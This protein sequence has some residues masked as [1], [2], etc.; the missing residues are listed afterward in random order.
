MYGRVKVSAGGTDGTGVQGVHCTVYSVKRVQGVH[1]TGGTGGT[2]GTGRREGRE[3]M[4][5]E[6][7]WHLEL[8]MFL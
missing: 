6:A 2:R 3:G 4:Y 1:C 5:R 7:E 8:T